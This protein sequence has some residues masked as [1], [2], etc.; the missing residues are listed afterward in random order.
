MQLKLQDIRLDGNTQPRSR[1]YDETVTA[2]TEAL[3]DGAKFPPVDV[4]FDGK[5]YWLAD[6]FHRY[7]AHRRNKHNTIDATIHKGTKRDAFIF[8]RGANAEHGM[9]RTNEEKRAVVISLLED[10]E[11]YSEDQAEE[12]KPKD[13]LIARICKVSNM[14]VGRI[15]KQLALNKKQSLPPAPPPKPSIKPAPSSPVLGEQPLTED[16]KM[17]ELAIEMQAIAEENAKLKDKL[18]I[19]SMDKSDEAK[20]EVEQTIEELREQVKQLE[21]ELASVTKSR[22]EFQNKAAEAIKQVQY[23]KRR[24]EKAERQAA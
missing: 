20:I 15:R 13:R 7:H 3:L 14:T 18:A 1:V 23:W 21:R 5:H 24:A 9:P 10:P 19:H 8:S 22:N 2:Y 11:F 12:D 4:F 16:D 6:G 17:Q